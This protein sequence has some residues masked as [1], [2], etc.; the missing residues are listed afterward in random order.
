MRRAEHIVA[1]VAEGRAFLVNDRREELIT[2]NPV[3]TM[4]WRA[5]DGVKDTPALA[6]E[7]I[8]EFE[9]VTS[10]R[11]R[12]DIDEFLARIAKLGLVVEGPA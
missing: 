4:V 5:L 3:G 6:A 9:D 1:E 7:L 12:T 8:G 2:L 10:E 11:L